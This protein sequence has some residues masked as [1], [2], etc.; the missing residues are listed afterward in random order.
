MGD[1]I[2][3]FFL[4]KMYGRFFWDKKLA[5]TKKWPY[6]RGGRKAGF[7]ITS[8][9]IIHCLLL[10]SLGDTGISKQLLTSNSTYFIIL[11]NICVVALGRVP[12]EPLRPCPSFPDKKQLRVCHTYPPHPP[13][14]GCRRNHD[15]ISSPTLKQFQWKTDAFQ[16][17]YFSF[18]N[19]VTG[20]SFHCKGC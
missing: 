18:L 20:V 10:F 19:H 3:V 16:K 14:Q 17:T 11:P 4:K 12:H 5:V 2:N 15:N 1:R 8:S 13:P 7:H 6:Y 9:D